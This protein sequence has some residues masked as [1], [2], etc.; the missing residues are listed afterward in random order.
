MTYSAKA[1]PSCGGSFAPRSSRTKWCDPCRNRECLNCGVT[2]RVKGMAQGPRR[3]C[4]NKCYLAH[5]WV[6]HRETITCCVCGITVDAAKSE[7]RKCCS[8]RCRNLLK[9]ESQ[10]GARSHFWRGGATT[11]YCDGWQQQRREALERDNNKCRSCNSTD[12]LNVHHIDPHR[13]SGSHDLNNLVTLCR[14]CHSREEWKCNP[15]WARVTLGSRW[16]TKGRNR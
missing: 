10:R 8:W 12:H 9:S 15:E 1:C 16:K 6:G 13:Y 14:S 2:Y 4:S 5:R 7:Q 3:F 11:P